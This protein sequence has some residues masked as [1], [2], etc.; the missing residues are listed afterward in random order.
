MFQASHDAPSVED[1]GAH[2][3]AHVF[4]SSTRSRDGA[5]S[6][7]GTSTPFRYSNNAEHLHSSRHLGQ[8][9]SGVEGGGSALE[10]VNLYEFVLCRMPY[11]DLS[12]LESWYAWQ[13]SN[14][15]PFA[16][17]ANALSI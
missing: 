6:T 14:L 15:R 2:L 9:R 10:N 5:G 12:P 17:E 1:W 3:Q 4:D 11:R 7:E 13:D 16:P 8:T